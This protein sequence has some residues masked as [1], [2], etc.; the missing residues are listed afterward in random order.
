MAADSETTPLLKDPTRVSVYAAN[1]DGDGPKE[2][3][4]A[5]EGALEGFLYSGVCI[6]YL[7]TAKWGHD[8]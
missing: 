6:F 4:D 7:I 8:S 5:R 3:G 2:D 1:E